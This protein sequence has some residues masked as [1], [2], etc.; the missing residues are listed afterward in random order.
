M[1]VVEVFQALCQIMMSSFVCKNAW[2]NLD[3]NWLLI[4]TIDTGDKALGSVRHQP[5]SL[6][7]KLQKSDTT[8][9]IPLRQRLHHV[10]T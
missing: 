7:V 9:T 10:I 4:D 8:I 2:R 1:W 3:E 5:L 6:L